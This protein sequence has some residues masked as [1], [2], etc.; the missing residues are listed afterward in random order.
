[1]N[2]LSRG[3]LI[4]SAAEVYDEFFVP[5]L[6][7]EWAPRMADAAHLAP[8]EA[9]LD[10]ACGTGVLAREAQARVAPG[11]T[12]HGLDRNPDMLAVAGLRE[13]AVHWRSGL[14]EALPFE[15]RRFD[16]VTCQFGLMFF[17]DRQT[18]LA[19]MWRVLR[20]GGRLLVAVWDALERTP[21]YAAM[22]E[23]LRRLFGEEI[24]DE[25]RAPFVLGDPAELRAL[26][27]GAGTATPE[28]HTPV[29]TAR[30]SS[31][32]DWVHTDVK[33]WTLADRIDDTQYALL[34]AEA[35]TALGRFCQ[36]DGT[37]VF[38]SPAHIVVV[39]K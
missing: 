20:P 2:D 39:R 10:V 16:V 14:A 26:F 7:G 13:P 12:V 4:R 35:T 29:G 30:F 5:A 1:M 9:V 21:G 24:A 22:V 31:I 11:G 17:E 19:E 27:A 32:E 25:L 33:G 23:L 6:F 38:D 3:Q 37:V 8:G 18:A 28:I 36:A 15:D 34:Q